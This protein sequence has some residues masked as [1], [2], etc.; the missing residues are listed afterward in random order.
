MHD[1]EK[2][3]GT[4]RRARAEFKFAQFLFARRLAVGQ[5]H[6]RRLG[7]PFENLTETS[8]CVDGMALAREYYELGN[9]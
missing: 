3:L 9:S 1:K 7:V 2:S 6:V 5:I 4:L 8:S